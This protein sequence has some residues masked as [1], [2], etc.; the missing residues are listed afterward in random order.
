ML[1]RVLAPKDDEGVTG[2][3]DPAR[4]A[5]P[6]TLRSAVGRGGDGGA[7]D[8][9]QRS[10]IGRVGRRASLRRCGVERGTNRAKRCAP[11]RREGL[12]GREIHVVR[13]VHVLVVTPGGGP[14]MDDIV[15]RLH[16]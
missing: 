12:D 8:A 10:Q 15:D 2:T 3:R 16:S 6:V 4:I 13:Y 14:A 5:I 1:A 11:R 9:L 7:G